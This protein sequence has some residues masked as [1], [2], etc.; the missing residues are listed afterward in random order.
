MRIEKYFE[1]HN[2]Y[3]IISNDEY[4]KLVHQDIEE[5]TKYE[6]ETITKMMSGI[7]SVK[8]THRGTNRN[9]KI[10]TI[11]FDTR[12][13]GKSYNTQTK[14][15]YIVKTIDEWY[16][17][18]ICSTPNRIYKCDQ[19]EGLIKFIKNNIFSQKYIKEYSYFPE[20][21]EYK[22]N[23]FFYQI[24][25][26]ECKGYQDYS[27]KFS[28]EEVDLISKMVSKI[29]KEINR[30]IFMDAAWEISID[31]PNLTYIEIYKLEDEWYTISSYNFIE[32]QS[33]KCDQ[34]ES[35]EKCL[36]FILKEELKR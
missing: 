34:I 22:D 20:S 15:Y 3:S 12:S 4:K 28:K 21:V 1:S 24:G 5:F 2:R 6:V 31:I 29:R 9:G 11:H 19:F 13:F 32:C 30:T 8:T 26:A 18:F 17:V 23:D 35:V 14:K 25:N 36:N 7:T 27:I 16:I 33:Y 10:D